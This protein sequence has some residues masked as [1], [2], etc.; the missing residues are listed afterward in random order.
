MMHK[1]MERLRE[2]SSYAGL[3]LLTLGLGELFKVNEAPAIA[4]AI[5]AAGQ[6]VATT[7][8]PLTAAV[9]LAG[10]ILSLIMGE[11]RR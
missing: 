4:D 9:A 1:I 5:N 6:A 11:R 7:G 3:G 10:G 2:P 8:D